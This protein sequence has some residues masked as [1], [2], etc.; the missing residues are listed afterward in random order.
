M[1]RIDRAKVRDSTKVLRVVDLRAG[2]LKLDGFLD[3]AA[4]DKYTF[5]RDAF[6][7]KRRSS[8]YKPGDKDK[9][10]DKDEDFSKDV[11]PDNKEPAK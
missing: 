7:Q 3:D 10:E 8:I 11:K 1:S 6:L 5:T 2:F 9:V 4:L